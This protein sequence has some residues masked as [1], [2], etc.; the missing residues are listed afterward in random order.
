MKE[1]N[2]ADT[3]SITPLPEVTSTSGTVR[4]T[5]NSGI[6]PIAHSADASQ[7]IGIT[8]DDTVNNIANNFATIINSIPEN[9]FYF[10]YSPIDGHW[11]TMDLVSVAL[12]KMRQIKLDKLTVSINGFVLDANED[13]QNRIS[14]AIVAMSDIDTIQWKGFYNTFG[15]MTKANLIEALLLAGQAQ[16]ELWL[17]YSL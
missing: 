17:K 7:Y 4:E 12:K 15:T 10:F 11:L 14:R 8:F 16:T 2:T 1:L 13:A 6:I 9:A 3:T 5:I